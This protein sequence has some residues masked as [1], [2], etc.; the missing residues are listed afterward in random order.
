MTTTSWYR[1]QQEHESSKET[2]SFLLRRKDLVQTKNISR[3]T[4]KIVFSSLESEKTSKSTQPVQDKFRKAPRLAAEL[5]TPGSQLD[6]SHSLVSTSTGS[7]SPS[8]LSWTHYSNT[9]DFRKGLKQIGNIAPAP[10]FSQR[11]GK[12]VNNPRH[13]EINLYKAPQGEILLV[14]SGPGEAIS[15]LPLRYVTEVGGCWG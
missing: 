4:T 14:Q 2:I 3:L 12:V 6:P 5:D 1:K 11:E 10:R 15:K 8:K 9:S 13:G 7:A